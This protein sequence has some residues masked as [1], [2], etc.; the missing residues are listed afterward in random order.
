M[1]KMPT[2]LKKQI[3]GINY[4][5]KAFV[6]YKGFL[7][8]DRMGLGK[9]AQ[10]ID[11]LKTAIRKKP[12]LIIVPAY[13]VYNWLDELAMWGV[14]KEVCVIDSGKQI[15]HDA[16]I[17]IGSYTLLTKDTIRKQMLKREFSLLICDEAHYL[18][19]WNT[20]RS[21]YILG[22]RKNTKSHY[23]NRSKRVLLL[24]GTPVLNRIDELYNLIWKIA[25]KTL[26]YSRE[27]FIY[28]FAAHIDYT[29]WG[30]KH[31]GLKNEKRLLEHIKPIFLSRQVIEGLGDRID[32]TIP[33]VKMDKELCRK[34]EAFLKEHN[35][36]SGEELQKVKQIDIA[37]I[38]ETRQAVGLFKMPFLLS[39][40]EDTL[41]K[42]DGPI[43]IYVY[44]RE[45]GRIL[46]ETLIKRYPEKN[47]VY[48][49]G[50]V[51]IKKRA[52]IVNTYQKGEIDILVASIGALREGV[53]LTAG[54]V[55]MFLELDWTPANI[56]QAIAR[57][58]RK[59]QDGTVYVYFF[60][61]KWGIDYRINTLLKNKKR[62]ISKIK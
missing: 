34:E 54:Q 23:M 17:Y 4:I 44:Y 22:T 40:I 12:A 61:C 55:V 2:L 37:K 33:I 15:I 26:P 30:L 14:K 36:Q 43:I 45:T 51:S 58:H 6:T 62:I 60:I 31:H 10:A 32:T 8:A 29:P 52:G 53:N 39:G 42:Q 48:V 28:N 7:L 56:E 1:L 41:C 21:R 35:V 57:L 11:L 59:G 27:E 18:K 25:P 20:I 38:A 47:V 3:D 50:A 9:T 49:N 19:G 5:K 16:S 13:L 24:T 46:K